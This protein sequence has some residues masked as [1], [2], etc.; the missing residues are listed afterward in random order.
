MCWVWFSTS[1][2]YHHQVNVHFR[3]RSVFY[4]YMWYYL[5][6]SHGCTLK[7]LL[8]SILGD[9]KLPV[10][11]FFFFFFTNLAQVCAQYISAL[12]WVWESTEST[13]KVANVSTDNP[14]VFSAAVKYTVSSIQKTPSSIF[15]LVRLLAWSRSPSPRQMET[16]MS[17]FTQLQYIE[18]EKEHRKYT[19]FQFS[20]TQ[21]IC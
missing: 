4:I 10:F 14:H 17:T 19:N 6:K 3:D 20:G 15:S 12:S 8:N 9:K 5:Q 1:E 11:F 16:N 21:Q 18:A 2:R 7:I 13:L